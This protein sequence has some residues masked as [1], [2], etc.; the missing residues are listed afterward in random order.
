VKENL[1]EPNILDNFAS[2]KKENVACPGK[3]FQSY[4]L[5]IA[6]I[7][8][9]KLIQSQKTLHN[10]ERPQTSATLTWPKATTEMLLD[11]NRVCH[12]CREKFCSL[13][14]TIFANAV[15]GQ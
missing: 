10:L 8:E 3:M 1:P 5:C 11:A 12:R 2:S 14:L 6:I 13:V 15:L 4:S 9:R 7:P